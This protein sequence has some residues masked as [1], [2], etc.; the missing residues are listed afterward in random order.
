MIEILPDEFDLEVT[1]KHI[2][3]GSRACTVRCAIALALADR[4]PGYKVIVTTRRVYVGHKKYLHSY[5]SRWFVSS[6]DHKGRESVE[7]STFHF[8]EFRDEPA[9]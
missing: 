3:E 1:Q 6:F 7:P 9:S 5:E 2:D 8:K 4:F